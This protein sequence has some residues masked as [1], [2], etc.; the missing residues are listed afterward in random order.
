V[1]AA[2]PRPQFIASQAPAVS[3]PP[4]GPVLDP[5][6]GAQALAQV[7]R[8]NI[9]MPRERL[10]RGEQLL[11]QQG[12]LLFPV[13]VIDAELASRLD[14]L[15]AQDPEQSHGIFLAEPCKRHELARAAS[16]APHLGPGW[17][18]SPR[19]A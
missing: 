16:V 12:D 17:N 7:E 8:I 9:E 13:G 5:Q 11:L 2:E 6:V 10:D 18:V 3:P 19:C 15:C 1:A 14:V 4:D